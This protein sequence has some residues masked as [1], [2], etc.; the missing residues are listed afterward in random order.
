MRHYFPSSFLVRPTKTA[1]FFLLQFLRTC[2][3]LVLVQAAEDPS[4]PARLESF[5][6]VSLL[7]TQQQL[8][9]YFVI[10]PKHLSQTETQHRYYFFSRSVFCFFHEYGGLEVNELKLLVNG[11]QMYFEIDTGANVSLVPKNI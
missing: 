7:A 11:Q 9:S 8:Q 5:T 2:H 4:Y 1:S 10:L 6:P 3:R